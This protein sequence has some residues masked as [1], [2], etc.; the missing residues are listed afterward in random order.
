MSIPLRT[1]INQ[2]NSIEAPNLVLTSTTWF[3]EVCSDRLVQRRVFRH[4]QRENDRGVQENLMR[5]LRARSTYVRVVSQFASR[6]VVVS[7]KD[8]I[9]CFI[10]YILNTGK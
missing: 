10:Y 2:Y 8:K 9:Y 5:R 7:D 4:C 6:L 3:T 1:L